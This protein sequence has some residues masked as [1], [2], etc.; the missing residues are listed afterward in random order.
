[1]KKKRRVPKDRKSKLPKKYLAGTAGSRRTKLAAVIKKIAKL[2][3]EGK[4][5]PKKLLEQRVKLG[6][7]K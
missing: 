1:M 3:K 4:R 2:Y 7:R 6:K 5:V